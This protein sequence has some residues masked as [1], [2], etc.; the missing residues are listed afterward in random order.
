MN[1]NEP[2]E[3]DAI[4]AQIL[5]AALSILPVNILNEV[6]G[7]EEFARPN[8]LLAKGKAEPRDAFSMLGLHLLEERLSR[9]SARM[10]SENSY[11]DQN[12]SDWDE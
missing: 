8:R 7:S 5:R 1:K 2:I 11:V 10:W 9:F 3:L 12:G 4:E 6:N